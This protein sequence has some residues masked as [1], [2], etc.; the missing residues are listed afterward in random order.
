VR[1]ETKP[2]PFNT[3][4][5]LNCHKIGTF[6]GNMARLLF[7]VLLILSGILPQRV[8]AQDRVDSLRLLMNQANERR[9]GELN[10]EIASSF[11]QEMPDS[12]IRYARTAQGIA[13]RTKDYVT[14]IRSYS[15]IGEA[16][17]KQN[18]LKEAIASYLKGLEL[19][20]KH[21]E[22]SLA[23]TIYNGI[24]V[25]YFYLN[26]LD[27]AEDY[28]KRAAQAKKEANDYQYYALIATN[29][30]GLQIMKQSFDESLNTLKDAE[31]TL[32]KKKQT[33]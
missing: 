10:L 1:M 13:K 17:Q 23:G 29:L 11:L 7:S 21:N 2:T 26:N 9:K 33:Q 3:K 28:M 8:S 6:E 19:A 25:C 15:M 30:A 20:E 5:T 24:G 31:K 4:L 22:K 12:T 27:K 32:L 16:Y 14:V 18:K